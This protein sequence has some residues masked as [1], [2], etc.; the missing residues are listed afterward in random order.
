MPNRFFAA[1]TAAVLMLCLAA[2]ASAQTG[3]AVRPDPLDASAA[4]PVTA[5]KSSLGAY[6]AQT[7]QEVAPWRDS[8]DTAARIGGWRAYA[9]EAR[10][11]TG[12]GGSPAPASPSPAPA[13]AAPA[14]TKKP[15]QHGHHMPG[16]GQ[17]A[18]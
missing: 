17:H 9:R 4:V 2:T 16:G 14:A 12:G 11:E 8:N 6:R 7:E 5:Y 13:D 15:M 3:G 18:H 10:G 1:P